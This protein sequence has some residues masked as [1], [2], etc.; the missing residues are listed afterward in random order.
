MSYKVIIT[1]MLSDM[2]IYYIGPGLKT[3][4]LPAYYMHVS[5][6]FL[7]LEINFILETKSM[8][9]G[10]IDQVEQALS[11]MLTSRLIFFSFFL[12]AIR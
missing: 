2:V 7:L 4:I 5:V 12:P 1:R 10:Q 9:Q 11:K 8:F 6:R 3:E